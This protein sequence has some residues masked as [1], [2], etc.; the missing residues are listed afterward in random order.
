MRQLYHIALLILSLAGSAVAQQSGAI[1]SQA[2]AKQ[3]FDGLSHIEID[4]G[5]RNTLLIGFRQYS[6]VQARQNVDSVLRLF[7]ADY[8]NVQDTTQ[9]PTQAVRALFRLDKADRTLELQYRLPP[10]ISFHFSGADAPTQV[11]TQQDTLQIVWWSGLTR[12]AAYDFSVYLLLNNLDDIDRL[13]GSGGVNQRVQAALESVR[14]YKGHDLTTPK[15]S[16][17]MVQQADKQPAFLRPGL[18]KNPFISFQPGIGAGLIRNQWVPSFNM[19]A[20]FVPSRLHNVGYSV[21]YVSNFFFAQTPIDGRYRTFRNDFLNVGL[22]FYYF[23]KDGRTSAF[24]RQIFSFYVGVPVHRSGPYFERDAIRLGGTA[25]QRGLLKVQ[26]EVYMN[27]LFKKVYPGLR[28]V[29]GF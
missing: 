6:Q 19:E 17:D 29:V 2:G 27:G 15:M 20:Q 5:Q 21:S 1:L 12:P 13:L 7:V 25:Y 10:T 9:N 24:S 28:L 23:N 11:K 22:A 18:A 16:F 8:R 14:Q 3:K 26:P 4:L